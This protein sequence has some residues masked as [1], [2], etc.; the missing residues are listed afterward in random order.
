MPFI[1]SKLW[2][3]SI[4]AQHICCCIEQ[5]RQSFGHGRGGRR[6]G[7][8][9]AQ[10][11]ILLCRTAR[12]TGTVGDGACQEKFLTIDAV[13]EVDGRACRREGE[14]RDDGARR[15]AQRHLLVHAGVVGQTQGVHPGG[16]RGQEEVQAVGSVLDTF[17]SH[18]RFVFVLVNYLG[19]LLVRRPTYCA[20][21]SDLLLT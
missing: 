20:M 19:A 1:T 6:T 9:V 16:L 11:D 8:A 14:V 7:D 12:A 18:N 5:R 13:A 4:E 17:T 3:E 2:N 10:G 15:V 21:G